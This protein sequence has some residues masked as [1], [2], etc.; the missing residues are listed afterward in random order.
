MR[1]NRR[2]AGARQRGAPIPGATAGAPIISA[3]RASAIRVRDT[4]G[5]ADDRTLPAGA[6]AV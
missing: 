5:S 4:S 3:G 1:A 2:G 6:L